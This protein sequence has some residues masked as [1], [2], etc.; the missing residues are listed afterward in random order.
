MV[1]NKSRLLRLYRYLYM[2]TD[3]K[4]YTTKA[5]IMETLKDDETVYSR[6]TVRDDID[7]LTGEGYDIETVVSSGN[8]YYFRDREFTLDELRVIG[9]AVASSRFIGRKQKSVILGKLKLFCSKYQAETVE[10]HLICVV[11]QQNGDASICDMVNTI[12][13]AINQGRKISFQLTEPGE[14]KRR[15]L[16]N[17]GENFICTPFDL[18]WDGRDYHLVCWS[19]KE[20]KPVLYPVK[21][22]VKPVILEE[23]ASE[24]PRGFSSELFALDMLS[25]PDQAAEEVSE[26]QLHE[27]EISEQQLCEE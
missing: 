3:D 22:I 17:G 1:S 21:R 15:K 24:R 25:G 6:Q 19:D 27:E 23:R 26:Q 7:T 12:N 2:N 4:H 18:A 5:E 20:G 8:Y 11:P 10:R 9:D 16:V 13:D 14:G